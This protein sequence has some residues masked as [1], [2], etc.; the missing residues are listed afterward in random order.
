MSD[1]NNELVPVTI[2]IP[3]IGGMWVL[4]QEVIGPRG[5]KKWVTRA[6][7]PAIGSVYEDDLPE[8]RYRIITEYMDKKQYEEFRIEDGQ[9]IKG[10]TYIKGDDE[11]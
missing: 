5:G 3:S 2:R 7:H 6:T 8:G 11:W 1:D 4:R 9:I 10:A